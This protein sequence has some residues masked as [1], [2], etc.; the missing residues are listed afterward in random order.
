VL[1]LCHCWRTNERFC[2]ALSG[3]GGATQLNQPRRSMIHPACEGAGKLQRSLHDQRK[4]SLVI[5]KP[6]AIHFEIQN[7]EVKLK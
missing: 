7:D 2:C 1:A 3:A 6:N 4:G 5:K